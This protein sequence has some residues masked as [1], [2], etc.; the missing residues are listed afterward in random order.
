MASA[1]LLLRWFLVISTTVE[2]TSAFIF[3]CL[4]A[5]LVLDD[6]TP[7]VFFITLAVVL[8][9]S[10]LP[11]LLPPL[12]TSSR[13]VAM[14]RVRVIRRLLSLVLDV[15]SVPSFSLATS[16][17]F[18]DRLILVFLLRRFS[19]C[20]FSSIKAIISLVDKNSSYS[21]ELHISTNFLG[22]FV[23]QRRLDLRCPSSMSFFISSGLMPNSVCNFEISLRVLRPAPVL[24]LLA[25]LRVSRPFLVFVAGVV[26]VELTT[27]G[28][29]AACTVWPF[30]GMQGSC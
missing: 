8:T 1:L 11:P 19:C 3:A 10:S 7:E 15:T 30:D 29:E 22:R 28:G 4:L 26:V 2:T 9:S 25:L 12:P 13:S 20:S 5:L 17:L 14:L 21:S 27:A 16:L 6:L 24:L 18:D 23:A